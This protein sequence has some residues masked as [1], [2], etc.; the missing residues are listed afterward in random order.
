MLALPAQLCKQE[1]SASSINIYCFTWLLVPSMLI[2]HP[3]KTW[4]TFS[5]SFTSKGVWTPSCLGQF[6]QLFSFNIQRSESGLT[7]PSLVHKIYTLKYVFQAVFDRKDECESDQRWP[8]VFRIYI[9]AVL[10]CSLCLRWHTSDK[11]VLSKPHKSS[12]NSLCPI[13]SL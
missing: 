8:T 10:W 7:E 5:F 13:C 6:F 9:N 1:S 4:Q 11:I 12:L 3:H 2:G